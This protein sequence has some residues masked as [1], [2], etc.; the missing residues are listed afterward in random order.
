MN[1]RAFHAGS[2]GDHAAEAELVFLAAQEL[3]GLKTP[4]N[5]GRRRANID[6]AGLRPPLRGGLSLPLSRCL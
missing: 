1:P 4:L 5:L 2:D 6:V 3:A